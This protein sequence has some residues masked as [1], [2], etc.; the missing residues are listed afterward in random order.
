VVFITVY[1]SMRKFGTSEQLPRSRIAKPNSD[2]V[3]NV[4]MFI[5][6]P[7]YRRGQCSQS[8]AD[9]EARWTNSHQHRQHASSKYVYTQ[10]CKWKGIITKAYNNN[11]TCISSFPFFRRL[12]INYTASKKEY[13]FVLENGAVAHMH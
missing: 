9:M 6:S 13:V 7:I 2:S 5:N 10:Q 1:L 11:P 4:K 12:K 3:K 8:T